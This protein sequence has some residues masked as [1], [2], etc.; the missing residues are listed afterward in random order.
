MT[1][2]DD[3]YITDEARQIALDTKANIIKLIRIFSDHENQ[4][5][6]KAYEHKS[7]EF[8]AFVAQF[9]DLQELMTSKLNTPMEEVNAIKESRKILIKKTQNLQDLRNTKKEAYD[10]QMEDC[11]KSRES[12]EVQK[13]IL[14][15]QMNNEKANKTS[16]ITDNE[17]IGE[18]NEEQLNENH[19]ANVKRLNSDITK[20]EKDLAKVMKNNKDAEQALRREYKKSHNAYTDN[21]NSYDYEMKNQTREKEKYIAEYED[22]NGEL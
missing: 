12:R 21:M 16:S 5:K 6:L 10:K 1:P 8:S 18:K 20:L 9:A 3:E 13:K 4:L 15:E 14:Q 19:A 11:G 17:L 2:L 22:T 7:G